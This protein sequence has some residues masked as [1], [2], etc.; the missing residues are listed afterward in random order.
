MI[1]ELVL[2]DQTLVYVQR[3]AA[4]L[5]K[6]PAILFFGLN[7]EIMV[8]VRRAIRTRGK[9]T[10]SMIRRLKIDYL[11][12]SLRSFTFLLPYWLVLPSSRKAL[13]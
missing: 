9:K 5:D 8:I 3:H 7:T 4:S 6:M 13:A 1:L 10:E 11:K 12:I 2:F